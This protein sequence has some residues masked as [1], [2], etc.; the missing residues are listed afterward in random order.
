MRP[1]NQDGLNGREQLA[2][3]AHLYI[4]DNSG[5]WSCNVLLSGYAFVGVLHLTHGFHVHIL[6]ACKLTGIMV[7]NSSMALLNG[8][9]PTSPSVP[10]ISQMSSHCSS[11]CSQSFHAVLGQKIVGVGAAVR[12]E[13]AF[14][15]SGPILPPVCIVPILADL[16]S[17]TPVNVHS[18][19]PALLLLLLVIV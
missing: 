4:I 12:V 15:P 9:A 11:G 17:L 14:L 2:L 18:L 1:E 8:E 3:L 19:L 16:P 10:D 13:L 5:E 6:R 7:I